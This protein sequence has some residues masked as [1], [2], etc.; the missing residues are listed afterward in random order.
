MIMSCDGMVTIGRPVA[1][2]TGCCSSREHQDAG[3]GLGLGR[4][5][6]VDGHLVT[7]EVGVERGAD[8]RVQVD[9]LALDQHRL[10][11]LDAE[12]VQGGAP[13]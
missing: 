4:Q 8:E 12:T 2:L 10:E 9:R 6:Q 13:G 1:G 7:V 5:R 3:L 11:G